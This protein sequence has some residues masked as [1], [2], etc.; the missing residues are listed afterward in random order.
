[1]YSFSSSKRRTF[2]KN[3]FGEVLIQSSTAP[4]IQKT[5]PPKPISIPKPVDT[6]IYCN[7]YIAP[8]TNPNPTIPVQYFNGSQLKSLYNVPN[9]PVASGKK[10][11]TIAI[12]I[13]YSYPS[14]L[15]DLKMYWQNSSNF[16]ASSNPPTV[17][18]YKMP[19]ATFNAGWAIEECLDVQMVCTINPNANIWVVEAKSSSA[20]DLLA[21]VKYA[22]NTI[23]ADV[24][25]MSWGGNDNT[26]ISSIVN[27]SYF[28]DASKCFCASSGDTNTVSW[29]AVS[30]NCIAVGG[31]TLLWT[32]TTPN[33]RTEYTWVNAGS[34][35]SITFPKPSY[36]SLQNTN[37]KRCIPDV[38]LIAG[39]NSMVYNYC[40][41]GTSNP[42]IRSAGTSV[43]APIFAAIVSI[44][45]QLRFNQ[46]K[47]ALTSVYSTTP[48]TP[49]SST[50]PSNNLQNYLYKTILTNA[51][52]YS[53]DFNDITI[54]NNAAG[55]NSPIY[56]AATGFDVAT[57]IGSPNVAAFCTDLLNL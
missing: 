35:Y 20:T 14:L 57:G 1:M 28:T 55:G 11:A 21:A 54:G 22:T 31:T 9:I 18:V 48:L 42:W 34:G 8:A 2:A 16:G 39:V 26:S 3:T 12:V 52:K 25:S 37:A 24:I 6:E 33:Q 53:S 29:P 5:V 45:D 41:Y 19:G 36:Q 43:S 4:M 50:P 46:G 23:Q 10:Q 49:T 40:S 32:P 47:S 15:S 13:A 17:R 56:N 30:T 44:A 38:S 51:G 27:N 7:Y